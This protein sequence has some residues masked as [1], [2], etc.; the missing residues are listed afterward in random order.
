MTARLRR[1]ATPLAGRRNPQSR[2]RAAG[3]P[4]RAV[5]PSRRHRKKSAGAGLPARL[6]WVA[7]LALYHAIAAIVLLPWRLSLGLSLTSLALTIAMCV[8]SAL[9]AVRQAVRAAPAGVF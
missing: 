7:A 4:R 8:Q 3:P 9:V 6:A 1:V 2:R 5:C